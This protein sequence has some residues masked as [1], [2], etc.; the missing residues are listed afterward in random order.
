MKRLVELSAMWIVAAGV[1]IEL[2]G[3]YLL[4]SDWHSW[5]VY[6]I[7]WG[8]AVFGVSVLIWIAIRDRR[9]A[10]KTDDLDDVGFN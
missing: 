10:S 9:K 7:G 8:I 6:A 1:V 2:V 5:F 4:L 3:I